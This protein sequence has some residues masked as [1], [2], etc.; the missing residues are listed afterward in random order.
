MTGPQSLIPRDMLT[1]GGA[2]F[3]EL[4]KQ[5]LKYVSPRAG[6]PVS[7]FHHLGLGFRSFLAH[8]AAGLVESA[9]G[10]VRAQGPI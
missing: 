2:S 7:L 1:L 8:P 4:E 5:N 9:R 3:Q 6:D 10:Q